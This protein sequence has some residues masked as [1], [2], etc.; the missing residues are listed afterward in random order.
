MRASLLAEGTPR[1]AS[2]LSTMMVDVLHRHAALPT[3]EEWL[4]EVRGDPPLPGEG[5][6]SVTLVEEGRRDSDVG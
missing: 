6:D 3:L 4:D 1:T 5:P 2:C